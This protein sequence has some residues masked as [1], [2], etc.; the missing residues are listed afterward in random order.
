MGSNKTSNID[1]EIERLAE[2]IKRAHETMRDLKTARKELDEYIAEIREI[3]SKEVTR[4][5]EQLGSVTTQSIDD[6]ELRIMKRFESLE[7]LI[8]QGSKED[9]I[10][11][12]ELI[13]RLLAKKTLKFLMPRIEAA[14]QAQGLVLRD[15]IGKTI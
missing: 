8:F 4:Q 14:A 6:C 11:I 5:V 12:D 3:M 13:N 15:E 7:K 2:A 10:T 1:D 9:D